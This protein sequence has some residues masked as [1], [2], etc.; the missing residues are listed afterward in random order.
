MA[1][2]TILLVEGNEDLHVFRALFARRNL[3]QPSEIKQHRGWDQLLKAI[4][5]RLQE[6]EVAGLGIV[7]DADTSLASRW[8]SVR[9]RLAEAGYAPPSQADPRGLVLNAPPDTILPRVGVWLMPNNVVP[10]KLEDFL[11]CLVPRGSALFAYAET[12]L[13]GIP[14]H[15]RLFKPVDQPKAL[16]H[17]WLAWQSE[18]GRPLGQ[19]ITF[20]FLE[21]TAAEADVLVRWLQRLFF[22]NPTTA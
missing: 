20:G 22:P 17:T 21:H 19:A 2:K 15:L 10:G 18:P 3:P 13:N 7:L 6:S 1:S 12:T 4:P 14:E 5:F 9:F 16:I 11:R 8:D